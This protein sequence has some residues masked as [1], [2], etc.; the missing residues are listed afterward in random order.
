MISFGFVLGLTVVFLIGLVSVIV[1]NRRRSAEERTIVSAYPQLVR[2]GRVTLALRFLGV[3][4]GFGL[5]FLV[6]HYSHN[7]QQYVIVPAVMGSLVVICSTVGE[8]AM[9]NSARQPGI[10]SLEPR[11]IGAWLPVGL[12]V[13]AGIG[14]VVFTWLIVGAWVMAGPD[15][16]DMVLTSSYQGEELI[17]SASG[18][19]FGW[20]Y[21]VPVIVATGVFLILTGIGGYVVA[22][23][24]RNGADPILAEWD[25]DL[26]RRSFRGL[27]ATVVGV[28]SADVMMVALT[29]TAAVDNARQI[30]VAAESIGIPPSQVVIDQNLLWYGWPGFDVFLWVIAGASFVGCIIATAIVLFDETPVR[31]DK[32][33]R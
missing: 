31:S 6:T 17:S 22:R 21:A 8:L 33:L 15:G 18:P 11:S 32:A 12:L 26:R 14:L 9:F 25:D 23:R 27:A 30:G 29:S 13:L 4:L 7:G 3:C 10:T 20:Y 24:P 2:F 1:W 28:V 5:I 19:F 16:Q